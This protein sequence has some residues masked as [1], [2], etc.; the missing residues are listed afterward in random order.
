MTVE[1]ESYTKENRVSLSTAQYFWQSSPLSR[2]KEGNIP[3]FLRNIPVL[4]NFTENELRVLSKY[5][6]NR[7]F[8]PKSLVFKEGESGFGFYFVFDGTVSLYMKNDMNGENNLITILDKHD[9]FGEL[10]LLQENSIRSASCITDDGCS[11]LGLFKPDLEELL[12]CNPRIAAKILQS[13][14]I[15][16]SERLGKITLD[17]KVLKEKMAISDDTKQN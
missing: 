11:L 14:S 3:K 6:H 13:I 8:A 4:K 12:E 10:A 16:I 1:K 17:L 7:T 5:L 9:Y 15:I 2:N